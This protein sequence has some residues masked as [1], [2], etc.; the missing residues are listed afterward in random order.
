MDS[1]D[2]ALLVMRGA[3]GLGLAYHGFNKMFGG[4][5]LTGT[6][7]WF[8]S[9]GMR[10][11]ALQARLAAFTEMGAG[12]LLAVGLLTPFAAAGIIGVMLVALWVAHRN[13]GFFIF[14]QGQ[15][16]EYTAFVAVVAWGLGTIGPGEASIDHAIDLRFEDWTGALIAGLLGVGSAVATLGAFYRPPAA[17]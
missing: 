14:N 12:V 13:N 4:G 15:G 7:A 6:A 2:V 1:I 3:V 8:G 5:G 17:P 11:P 9:I 10:H 16:W